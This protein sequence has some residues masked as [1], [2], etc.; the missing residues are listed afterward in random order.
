MARARKARPR[1]TAI[2]SGTRKRRSLALV[3]STSVDAHGEEEDL[4]DVEAAAIASAPG[5]WLQ[6][7]AERQE[8]VDEQRS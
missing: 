7:E 6:R 3:T 5:R 1:E 8:E 4:G 2:S